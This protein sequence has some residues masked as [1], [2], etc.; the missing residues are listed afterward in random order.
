MTQAQEE[1]KVF[2]CACAD[3][4]LV[5][6]YCALCWRWSHTGVHVLCLVL[7]LRLNL[8]KTHH[9]LCNA[10]LGQQCSPKPLRT[11][12]ACS[13]QTHVWR[14]EKLESQ[15][16]NGHNAKEYRL[17]GLVNQIWSTIERQSLNF[18]VVITG[19]GGGKEASDVSHVACYTMVTTFPGLKMGS[20]SACVRC[21]RAR[22]RFNSIKK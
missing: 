12:G 8:L 13:N 17:D 21:A 18:F 14:P 6:T 11:K 3:L 19:T 1:G 7:A 15:G 2:S 4:T 5:S 9:R 20:S 16:G 10:Q 22:T